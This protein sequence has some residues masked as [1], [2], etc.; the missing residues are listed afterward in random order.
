[1]IL[2]NKS[3]SFTKS[4]LGIGSQMLLFTEEVHSVSSLWQIIKETYKNISYQK[5][6]L[7]LD[8]LFSLGLIEYQEGMIKKVR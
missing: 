6:I 7:T 1:M 5:F 2:P 4:I 3:T 8:L